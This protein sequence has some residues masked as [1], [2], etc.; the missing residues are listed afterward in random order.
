[1]NNHIDIFNTK[2]N[3]LIEHLRKFSENNKILTFKKELNKLILDIIAQVSFG[4]E[5]NS[6]QDEN[7]EF[8]KSIE[9]VL[10]GLL[11]HHSDPFIHVN[12]D[13]FH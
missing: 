7:N 9:I 1:M 6:L 10:A 4:W 11:E 2:G 3:L 12:F 5:M 8:R 13:F